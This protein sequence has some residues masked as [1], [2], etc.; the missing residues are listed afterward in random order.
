[1]HSVDLQ[2]KP[3]PFLWAGT[4]VLAL[5]A[6][7][8]PA[9]G[10]VIDHHFAERHHNHSHIYIGLPNIDHIHPYQDNHPH[11]L[12]YLS[13]DSDPRSRSNQPA[14]TVFLAPLDGLEQD[15]QAPLTP[16][17][18]P[19]NSSPDQGD[20][21]LLLAWPQSDGPLKEVYVPPLKRPP[22]A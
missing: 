10:P 8:S 6:L 9:F 20:S 21:S 2:K 19:M 12:A 14:D 3:C 22:R 7:F 4:A 1:M 11:Q 16:A 15:A 17:A 13:D 18:Q 5:W